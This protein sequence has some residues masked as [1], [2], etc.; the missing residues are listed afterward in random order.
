MKKIGT[1]RGGAGFGGTRVVVSVRRI[2]AEE[3]ENE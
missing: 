1:E 3:E 2:P